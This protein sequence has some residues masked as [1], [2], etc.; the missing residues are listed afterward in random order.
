[1][2]S[3]WICEFSLSDAVE[4]IQGILYQEY[5]DARKNWEEEREKL[6]SSKDQL[7]AAREQDQVHVGNKII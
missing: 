2:V 1:M 4:Y 5:S 6:T 3:G 7:T